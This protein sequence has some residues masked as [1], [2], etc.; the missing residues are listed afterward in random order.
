MAGLWSVLCSTA[1][2]GRCLGL[3]G[4][5]VGLTWG[6][7]KWFGVCFEVEWLGL[8]ALMWVWGYT[9]RWC[10]VPNLKLFNKQ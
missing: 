10:E 6:K 8:V 5:K 4:E 3:W 1:E 9:Q 7:V 2:M